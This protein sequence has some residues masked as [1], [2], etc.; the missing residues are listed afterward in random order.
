M[1]DKEKY[2]TEFI[3]RFEPM[4]KTAEELGV[5]RRLVDN[6]VIEAYKI[7]VMKKYNISHE[8]K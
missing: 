7:E 4:Y 1:N 3:D 8:I 6:L 5:E 2:W